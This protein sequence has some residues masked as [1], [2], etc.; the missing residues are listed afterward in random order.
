[1]PGLGLRLRML[2]LRV[3]RLWMLGL[4][5]PRL[6]MLRLRV[7]GLRM[8]GLGML[9]LRVAMVSLRGVL[10]LGLLKTANQ[11]YSIADGNGARL[12]GGGN[13]GG[14]GTHKGQN[15]DATKRTELCKSVS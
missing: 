6:R 12:N 9:G 8:L 10:E 5:V 1:M 2:G 13:I 3:P 15:N 11:S 14:G 4:R 7:P